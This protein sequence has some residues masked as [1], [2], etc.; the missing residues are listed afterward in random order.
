MPT[1]DLSF[2]SYNL[3]SLRSVRSGKAF[4]EHVTFYILSNIPYAFRIDAM[5]KELRPKTGELRY[6]DG[7]LRSI[8]I[9]TE[10]YVA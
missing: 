5:P 1:S 4:A 2:T 10:L 6:M 9:L 3:P 7:A 8:L